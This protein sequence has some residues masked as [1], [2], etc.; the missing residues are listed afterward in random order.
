MKKKFLSIFLIFSFLFFISTSIGSSKNE[1]AEQY[2]QS[3]GIEKSAIKIISRLDKDNQFD[4]L[5]KDFITWLASQ[6]KKSQFKLAFKYA[7]DGEIS[8]P[9]MSEILSTPI[10]KNT[11]SKKTSSIKSEIE[12]LI[13]DDFENKKIT[14]ENKWS[15]GKRKITHGNISEQN[16]YIDTK[17]GVEKNGSSLC[18]EYSMP[19]KDRIMENSCMLTSFC[20]G[21]AKKIWLDLMEFLFL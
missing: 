6:D 15:L 8:A 12:Y 20:L 16:V 5:E 7:F 13:L 2:A 19:T 3:L 10:T 1:S 9:E 17:T 4:E 21:R 14:K 11:E 18:M